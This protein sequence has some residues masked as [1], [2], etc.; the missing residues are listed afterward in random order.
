M[1]IKNILAK[2]IGTS[3]YFTILWALLVILKIS[4]FIGQY[5]SPLFYFLIIYGA[6]IIAYDI[7]IERKIINKKYFILI[8]V[9]LFFV[10]LSTIANYNNGFIENVKIL[11]VATIQFI[12]IGYINM[13]GSK[14]EIKS[15][16]YI[17]NVILI[18]GVTIASIVSIY[19]FLKGI[20]GTYTVYLNSINPE[21]D[22]YYYGIATIHDNR[23]VGI[24]A[25]PNSVGAYCAIAILCCF[26]NLSLIPNRIKLMV[27][28]LLSILINLV[29]IAL[30]DSRGALLALLCSIFTIIFFKLMYLFRKDGNVFVKFSKSFVVSLISIMLVYGVVNVSGQVMRKIPSFLNEEREEIALDSSR[31]AI[32]NEVDIVRS[33]NGRILIWEL[34]LKT[35]KK[36]PIF[37]VGKARLYESLLEN[38]EGGRIPPGM[39]AGM[40][41]IFMETLVS[42]G[43]PAFIS[44]I[45]VIFSAIVD[46]LK[47]IKAV[48]CHKSLYNYIVNL[49]GMLILLI[50]N[51]M[52]ESIMLYRSNLATFAFIFY[53]GITI[54]FQQYN[55]DNTASNTDTS[56]LS[57]KDII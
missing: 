12:A 47:K 46:C 5:V 3:T 30:S 39:K 40:H 38:L 45:L 41:N 34:G 55:S 18:T 24:F 37:G 19:L 32:S 20:S 50:A 33:S 4:P 8:W 35:V 21:G 25:N 52:F 1:K 9:F 26:V 44:L 31:Q 51:N 27:P 13:K 14:D 48:Y 54:Y 56:I 10:G 43:I 16:V 23:L 29:S 42:Y 22:I 49:L 7:F 57:Q 15:K 2:I 53:L 36:H 28:Y 6:C 17:V 11:I